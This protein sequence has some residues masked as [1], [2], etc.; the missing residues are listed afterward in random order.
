MCL[1]SVIIPYYNRG[2]TLPRA[3]DSV[4]AQTFKDL[5][6]ILVNDGTTDQSEQVVEEYIRKHP[7][8]RFKHLTQVNM[9]PSEARNNGVRNARGKF[10]A[11]LDSD[12]SWEPTKLEIQIEYMEKNPDVAITGTNYYIVKDHK[13]TRYPLKSSMTE[14][15]YYRMLFKIVFVCTT[16]VIRSEVFRRDN[17][18]FRTGKS[19]GEDILLFLQ[20]LRKHRGV[21]FSTPLAS[22][23][24]L[25]YGE[26]D[27]LTS[28]LRKL[29]E[30]ER[31][32]LQVLYAEN[33]QSNKKISLPLFW[34]LYYFYLLKHLK[35]RL[36]SNW[37]HYK[38]SNSK[39][40]HSVNS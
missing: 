30:G 4:L 20:I 14:A 18:W 17:I 9:G 38:Y 39:S 15:D 2:D 22:I 26:E 7:Q 19:Q 31:S 12:D 25:D 27:C 37:Y 40:T 21:R 5:E 10:V 35:R 24:K 29:L 32:N 23:Y 1:V 6:I 36:K 16:A 3:L 28:N 34:L 8:V 11:F 33:S 13:W